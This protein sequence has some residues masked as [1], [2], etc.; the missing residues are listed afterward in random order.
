MTN[1]AGADRTI[2][3]DNTARLSN[4]TNGVRQDGVLTVGNLVIDTTPA[5]AV[6]AAEP[7]TIESNGNRT[8]A[9]AIADFTGRDVEKLNLVGAQDLTINVNQIAG[10]AANLAPGTNTSTRVEVD[11]SGLTGKLNLALNST[12]LNDFQH[13]SRACAADAIVGTAGANDT[14]MFYGALAAG[15]NTRCHR[16]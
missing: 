14:V 13:P 6:G 1:D 15:N 12:Q 4:S 7:V 16:H 5:T 10:P 2:T 3:L 11:A 8:S 9:N